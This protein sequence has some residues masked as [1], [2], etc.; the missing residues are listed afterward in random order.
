ML[1]VQGRPG[2]GCSTFLEVLANQRF[3]YESI[4]GEVLYGGTD[5]KTMAK[6]YR[7]EVLYNPEDDL[8]YATLSV[9]NT[10]PSMKGAP[11]ISKPSY[12]FDLWSVIRYTGVDEETRKRIWDD[13]LHLTEE[14]YAIMGKAIAAR[15]FELSV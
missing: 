13:G 7:G 14:G 3:G 9:K 12:N 4:D 15:L 5:A 8:H 6:H 2:S 10:G 11:D 1:L